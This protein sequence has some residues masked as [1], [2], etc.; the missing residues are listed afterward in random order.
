MQYNNE[1]ILK[2]NFNKIINSSVINK[3]DINLE[4]QMPET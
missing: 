3:T 2:L 1:Q 4:L